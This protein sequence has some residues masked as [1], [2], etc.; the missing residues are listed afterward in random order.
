LTAKKII[1]TGLAGLPLLWDIKDS[2]LR[3]AVLPAQ[4]HEILIDKKKAFAGNS[5]IFSN[6]RVLTVL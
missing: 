2:R 5:Y 1:L 3:M 6:G 4:N